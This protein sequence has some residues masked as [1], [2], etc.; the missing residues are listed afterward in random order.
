MKKNNNLCPCES[1]KKY[2]K[3]C[4]PFHKELHLP[5]TA[6]E[7]LRSRFSA[8]ALKQFDYLI[9]TTHPNN[10]EYKTNKNA[11]RKEL[12]ANT[13]HTKFIHL[14]IL[15]TEQLILLSANQ[16]CITFRVTSSTK[17]SEFQEMIETSLFEKLKDKW[18]YKECKSILFRDM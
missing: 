13:Q 17:N 2:S 18:L 4:Q 11:W 7:L 1:G 10:P 9:N 3:C 16:T 5:A 15:P 8:Y 12:Q 6:L 14:T